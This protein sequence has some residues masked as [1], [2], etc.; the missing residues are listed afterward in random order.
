MDTTNL[1]NIN[2]D[3][4]VF[5]LDIGTRTV[6]G[7][8]GIF[9]DNKFKIL[10]SEILEHQERSMY[11]GQ[12]H[13]IS[14]VTKI[15]KKVKERIETKLGRKLEKVSIAAAGRALETIRVEVDR[16]IDIS[17]EISKRLV[18][19]LEM[20]AIQHAQEMLE[21]KS[22]KK[23]SQYYCVGYTVINYYLDDNIIEN[24]EG[25]K[26]YKISADVL[27]TFLPHTVVDSLYTVMNR[28]GLEV[29]NL[30][31]E[32]IAAINIAIKKS[33]RLLNLALVDIGAGTSDIAITKD[34]SIIAYAMASIAGD[35][36]TEKIAKTFLLDYDVA[37]KLKISLSTDE[38][39]KFYDVVGIEHNLSTEEILDRVKDSIEELAREISDKIL[40][41]NEKAPSVIFL[42]G[43][44]SQI[45]TLPKF[46]ANFLDMPE[47]R[48]V[49]RDTSIIEDV[50]GIPENLKGP[51][52]ITPLGIVK[53]AIDNQ[54]K[55][56]LEIVINGQ[57]IKLFNSKQL[58]VS[59]ALV[60]IGYNPRNLI[61]KRGEDFVYYL[62]GE[63]KR[64][65]GE[66]GEPAKIYVNGKQANLEYRLL[67]GDDIT[68]EESL[69]GQKAKSPMLNDCINI[70][71]TVL[72]NDNEIK[73]IE[74]IKVNGE[75]ITDNVLVNEEDEIELR[76]I[77]N[78]AKL[79][80][81]QG[82][83]FE[84]FN[85]SV[86]GEEV[87][88]SYELQNGDV[89]TT[90]MTNKG[91]N[92]KPNTILD[93]SISEGNKTIRL[94]INN[95]EKIFKYNKDKFI[96]VDIFNYIDFNLSKSNGIIILKINGKKA[97]YIQELKNGDNIEIYWEKE[98][99]KAY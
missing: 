85:V 14:G 60:L 45:A 82:L 10:A 24:L 31:L 98:I 62:N 94:I 47:V 70:D 43:G 88:N 34:G 15:T 25:H 9:E 42:I 5:S 99:S 50:E 97:E 27:A 33:L 36:I 37:E 8:A 57:K 66:V 22:A 77:N 91:K 56:F 87:D 35:E 71:K 55:D 48:V 65:K 13:D 18:E 41:Y 54:Y 4:L 32:P 3:E 1:R 49:V 29:V 92:E 19:S 76:E 44:G 20:E 30:T 93:N 72:L 86:N 67:N 78:I 90:E 7:V 46:I 89:I 69:Q 52:A 23:E 11:D 64:I 83:E 84:N 26:G 39:H 17:K 61:P 74:F 80:E 58:K 95:E 53:A 51:N 28:V 81:I 38:N 12:I 2:D 63:K 6:I 75:I 79:F 68:V 21:K 59:N 40:K 96:F 73:L 16:Q